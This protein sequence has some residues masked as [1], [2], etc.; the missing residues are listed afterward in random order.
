MTKMIAACKGLVDFFPQM[1]ESHPVP[2]RSLLLPLLSCPLLCL[3][4]EDSEDNPTIPVLD[5]FGRIGRLVLRACM[6]KGVK[7]VAV[8][9]PFID[10]EYM[11]SSR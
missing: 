8:N 10:P 7:V 5:R 4:A 2:L 3:L 1:E 9:D 6:Q 11:V